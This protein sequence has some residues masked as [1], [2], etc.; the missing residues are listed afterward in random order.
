MNQQSKVLLLET[1]LSDPFFLFSTFS[2][3][4]LLPCLLVVSYYFLCHST[5]HRS[6]PLL[7]HPRLMTSFLSRNIFILIEKDS[8]FLPWHSMP[9]WMHFF[10]L[11]SIP[12]HQWQPLFLPPLSDRQTESFTSLFA[13][14]MSF[15]LT[16][17]STEFHA[18]Q[19]H[20]PCHE[21]YHERSI[22]RFDAWRFNPPLGGEKDSLSCS[23]LKG[24][25]R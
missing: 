7:W 12:Q 4:S 3:T 1:P 15:S 24:M 13:G 25:R 9:K 8:F 18:I 20:E 23:L 16:F 21:P 5:L 19:Y 6:S 2:F 22:K 17:S 10:S 14:Q 11:P